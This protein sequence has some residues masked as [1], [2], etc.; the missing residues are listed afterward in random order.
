MRI[1]KWIISFLITYIGIIFI[2]CESMDSNYK[3]YLNEYNYSGKIRNLRAYI[4]YERVIL[5]WDNPS[6]QKSKKIQIVYHEGENEKILSYDT[7][8][9]SISVENLTSES[10]YDFTIYTLDKENNQSVPV[11]ISALPVSKTFVSTLVEPICSVTK[12]E[13]GYALL[14]NNLSTIMMQFAGKIEY[15]ISGSNGYSKSDII[16]I[17]VYETD[18]N[19]NTQIKNITSY[20]L[21]TP[22]LEKGLEYTVTYTTYV[23]PILGKITEDIVSV[24]GVSKITPK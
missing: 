5:A 13:D 15:T 24:E 14:W 19:G 3:Q 16:D 20:M 22:E 12:T 8:I 4:G 9:D 23:W 10:G 21:N 7:L 1:E 17:Q 6:D 2:S 11:S 18:N